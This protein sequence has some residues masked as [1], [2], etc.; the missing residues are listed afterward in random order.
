MNGDSSRIFKDAWN[1]LRVRALSSRLRSG[2]PVQRARYESLKS[3]F[4]ARLHSATGEGEVSRFMTPL[5]E[6][7]NRD[8]RRSFSPHPP[9]AFLRHRLVDRTMFVHSPGLIFD[10]E[11]E[12]VK[13]QFADG[14]LVSLIREDDVG[15]PRLIEAATDNGPVLTSHN[16][17]HH[18][19][20]ISRFLAV[21]RP[22]IDTLRTIVEWG[23]GYGNL[24]KIVTRW[25]PGT[26]YVIVDTPLFSCIQWLYLSVVFGSETVEFL[27]RRTPL[28]FGRINVLPNSFADS[29]ALKADLFISTWALSESSPE[30][31][32]YVLTR[33]WFGAERLLLAYQLHSEF[34]DAHRVGLLAR[35]AGAAIERI[36]FLPQNEYAFL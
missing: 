16:T 24:A 13:K 19:Y 23:G 11:I 5:W 30:A 10:R 20:H 21:A 14:D 26:T 18:A 15:K 32:D 12:E 27:D 22:E 25:R 17:V 29:Y 8:I 2:N 4:A 1:G 6:S 9:Y 31:Q 33:N 28:A 34:P 36:D 7:M 35:D 3:T